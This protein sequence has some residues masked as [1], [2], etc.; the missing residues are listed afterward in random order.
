VR[1]VFLG[2]P[3]VAVPTL[4][5]LVADGHEVAAVVTRPDRRRGRGSGLSPSPVKR[6]ATA[7]SLPV[8]H[9]LKELADTPA[10]RGV[11]VAYG[12]L[13]PAALLERVP[14]LNVHFSLLPRWRG[15]A[16]VERAL[17]AGDEE[18]GVSIMTLE[19]TL[20][21][22]PVHLVRRTAVGTKT[23][24]Q[25]FDELARE[26]AEALSHVLANPPLLDHPVAQSGEV[27][28]AEKLTS[29]D[30]HVRASASALQ[31]LRVV[32]LGRAFLTVNDERLVV[33]EARASDATLPEGTIRVVD[34][35][36]LAGT[37]EGSFE[38][39]RV[40]PAGSR[41]MTGREWWS[42]QRGVRDEQDWD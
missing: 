15:A 1:L 39:V 25:L 23:L 4:E 32:R 12:A 18:T 38:L 20:D 8:V 34:G 40:R 35:R 10:E 30:Y 16:P 3:E 2:T 27:T 33:E 36:V 22:G 37:R 5:R 26:G 42:G 29:E 31:A 41:S 7:L 9:S 11:V 17:L 6:A 13:V 21:T 28:Y 14:M 19:P 24:A